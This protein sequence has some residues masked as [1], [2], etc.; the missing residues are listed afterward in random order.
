M[1]AH[2]YVK[3]GKKLHGGRRVLNY[4]NMK[5]IGYLCHGLEVYTITEKAPTRRVIHD[6]EKNYLLHD[7]FPAPDRSIFSCYCP[8]FTTRANGPSRF[9]RRDRQYGAATQGGNVCA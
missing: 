7:P 1:G 6:T 9:F 8:W 5:E 4:L 2:L 3:T